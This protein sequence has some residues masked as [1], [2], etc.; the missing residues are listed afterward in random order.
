M[1]SEKAY[2]WETELEGAVLRGLALSLTVHKG[3]GRSGNIT[4]WSRED[5]LLPYFI[6]GHLYLESNRLLEYC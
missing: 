2:L 6:F 5:A 3:K 1:Y 4:E